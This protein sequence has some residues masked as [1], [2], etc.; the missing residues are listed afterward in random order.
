[1][2][3]TGREQR[4]AVR[5]A[6]RA[7]QDRHEGPFPK[8]ALVLGS[9]LGGFGERLELDAVIPYT[10]IPGFPVSTVAGH[11]GRLLIGRAGGTPAACMQGRVHLY[12]GRPAQAL[13]LPVRMLRALGAETLI[14]TNA[15]G[16]L[17]PDLTPGSLMI[18]EDH[19]NLSGANP[20]TGLNDE[21]TGPRFP[22]M[23][24]AYDADLRARLKQAA[25]EE[26]VPISSGVYVQLPGPSFETPA[27]IRMLRTLGADAVGMSTAIECIAARHC[28]LRVA[29]VSVITNLAAGL[30]PQPLSHEETVRVAAQAGENLGRVLLRFLN[31]LRGHNTEFTI[32][33][34]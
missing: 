7:V 23:S 20:L 33:G 3:D 31:E 16:G 8:V 25:D 24:E 6:A 34:Q 5:R 1:M 10:E 21:E 27:E 26:A 2:P 12:E 19:I 32:T 29:A 15:A 4:A 28:G 17:R 30:S 18:V 13:A 14:L 9:G 22:D 11:A